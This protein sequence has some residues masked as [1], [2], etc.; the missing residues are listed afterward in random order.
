MPFNNKQKKNIKDG[1]RCVWCGW[2]RSYLDAAH[3]VDE[4]DKPAMNGIMLCANCHATFDNV[5]RPRLFQALKAYGIPEE[6]LPPS[7]KRPNKLRSTQ[8]TT[9]KTT[10]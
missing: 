3:V 10:K 9:D 2:D 4:I 7:W 8:E 6:M 5:F 1:K